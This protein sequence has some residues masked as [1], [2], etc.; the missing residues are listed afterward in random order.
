MP[1]PCP[2]P[3]SYDPRDGVVSNGPTSSGGRH[4]TA[5]ERGGSFVQPRELSCEGH[6]QLRALIVVAHQRSA[7]QSRAGVLDETIVRTPQRHSRP[8]DTV[9]N[10]TSDTP[11]CLPS[12]S[13]TEND[14]AVVRLPSKVAKVERLT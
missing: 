12:H 6:Q 9:D 8:V 3:R 11:V 10:A 2:Q 7:A 4:M 14:E 13:V 1:K 5:A